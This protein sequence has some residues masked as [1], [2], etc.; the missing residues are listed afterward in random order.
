MQIIEIDY[1]ELILERLRLACSHASGFIWLDSSHPWTAIEAHGTELLLFNPAWQNPVDQPVLPILLQRCRT[2][3]A[4]SSQQDLVALK[5]LAPALRFHGGL[6]GALP[7]SALQ[8][9]HEAAPA[10]VRDYS[11]FVEIQHDTQKIYAVVTDEASLEL[12]ER[13]RQDTAPISGHASFSLTSEWQWVWGANDYKTAFDRV[14]AYLAAGDCYQ[15]N[16]TQQCQADFK[17]H[18]FEAYW[19]VRKRAR[20]P[21]SAFVSLGNEN[22]ALLC[23]SPERFIRI[24]NGRML[25]SPIK[26]TRVRL[27]NHALDQIQ[28]Q[29]LVNSEKDQAENV[30]IVDLLR[31]DLS[32]YASKGS[33]SVPELFALHS[34]SNVHH[35]ISHVTAE[36]DAA[37]HPLEALFGCF[38]GGS[39]TGAPKQRARE[40]IDE[41]EAVP[42]GY[43]CG[44]VFSYSRNGLLDSNIAIR[45][46]HCVGDRASVSGGGG[47]TV[48]SEWQAEY[49][50]SVDKIRHLMEALSR[51]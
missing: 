46:V 34:F 24:E 11:N 44:A 4:L 3:Q 14:Q 13:V 49:D 22:E 12:V 48:G 43:Y 29:S 26:G 35:L 37:F 7:Y 38:P 2:W 51:L 31:N 41:L 15:I 39:I 30:M 45:S 1:S 21:F 18:P 6:V 40:I 9:E 50:E 36:L 17:G 16:L 8:P 10:V 5:T 47:I 20:A 27:A 23:F 19:Q 32:R 25:T 28:Q 33:V 42:R